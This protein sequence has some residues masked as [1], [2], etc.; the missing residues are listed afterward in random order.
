MKIVW[1]K[2]GKLLPVNKGSRIRSYHILR[3]LARHHEVTLLTY[4]GGRRDPAY[5]EEIQQHFPAAVAVC[6]A[7]PDETLAERGVHYLRHLSSAAPFSVTKFTDPE[8]QRLLANWFRER[9]FDAAVC[10]FLSAS[11]NFPQNLS[12]PTVL[13]QHNVESQLWRRQAQV[14]SFGIKKLVFKIEASKM[15][16][17]E[18]EAV[19]RFHHVIA[20][21]E[22]DREQMSAMTDISRITVVPTGVDTEQF[23]SSTN[24]LPRQPLVLFTGDMNWEPNIDG[25]IYFCRE[26]WPRVRAQVPEARFRI[27]GRDPHRT[28]RALASESIEVTGTV[29][30]VIEHLR[31]ARV[32]VVPLRMGGGTRLKIY[33]AMAAGKA[34]VSST[35]GAEGLDIHHGKDILLADNP[36]A[37]AESTVS[38]LQN[39]EL[40]GQYAKAA[41]E[42]AMR[43]DW[44]V[45]AG[46]FA[47][48]LERG[49]QLT[50]AVR[51]AAPNAPSLGSVRA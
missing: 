10:D 9:R 48:V 16:R 23:R 34:V 37:F 50:E 41:V 46:Q 51:A 42:L 45:I 47:E 5:E 12:T 24:S 2:A 32:F 19:R 38:L 4:Y 1:V 26:V 28:I 7:A 31:E 29:P 6:T 49:V 40:C 13:F 22:Q 43:H 8:V 25:V 44:S 30:S 15:A 33:E 21:S 18:R 35:V 17:Y 27:V 36:T 39:D 3:H 11:L 14:Q 20:V